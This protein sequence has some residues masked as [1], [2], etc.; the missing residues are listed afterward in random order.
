MQFTVIAVTWD[1]VCEAEFGQLEECVQRQRKAIRGESFRQRS[2][3]PRGLSAADLRW[4]PPRQELDPRHSAAAATQPTAPRRGRPPKPSAKALDNQR[5]LSCVTKS[6]L[7]RERLTITPAHSRRPSRGQPLQLDRRLRREA[8][9]SPVL[10]AATT[11]R[12]SRTVSESAPTHR[13]RMDRRPAIL[14]RDTCQRRRRIHTLEMLCITL[15]RPK[16]Y[17]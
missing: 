17:K 1:K 10:P 4:H 5:N 2:F 7:F 13:R 8:A 11:L 14:L 16:K 15:K 12:K 6:V 3:R 9:T